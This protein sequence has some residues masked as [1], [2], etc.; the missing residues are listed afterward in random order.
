MQEVKTKGIVEEIKTIVDRGC[1][2]IV[3]A[4]KQ[5]EGAQNAYSE[6]ER[7]VDESFTAISIHGTI[8]DSDAGIKKFKDEFE[9][10]VKPKLQAVGIKEPH[11]DLDKSEE[12]LM[13]IAKTYINELIGKQK[14]K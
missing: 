14:L 5:F 2:T 10:R 8:T 13:K 7:V 1:V 11:Q 9:K 4:K 6:F 12:D 3:G